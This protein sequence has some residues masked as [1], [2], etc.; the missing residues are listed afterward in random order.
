MQQGNFPIGMQGTLG[1]VSVTAG[2]TMVSLGLLARAEFIS[3]AQ[4]SSKT[5]SPPDGPEAV[6]SK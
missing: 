1:A 4:K 6:F 5:D 3:E 2:T